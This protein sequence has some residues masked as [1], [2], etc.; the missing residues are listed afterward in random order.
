VGFFLAA[1]GSSGLSMR[2]LSLGQA[3]AVLKRISQQP[4]ALALQLQDLHKEYALI[5]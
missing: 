5:L 3:N 4:L 2:M 1:Q